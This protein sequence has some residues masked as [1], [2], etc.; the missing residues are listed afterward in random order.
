MAKLK[1]PSRKRVALK[2]PVKNADFIVRAQTVHDTMAANT[3]TLPS[4][5]PALTV[6]GA[7]IGTLIAKEAATK[8][9][10]PGAAADRDAARKVVTDDLNEERAYVETLVNAD[11]EHGVQIAAA[12]AMTLT[13]LPS[14]NKSDLAVKHGAVTGSVH[15]VAKAQKGAKA[16]EW[17]CSTDGGK[18]WT[19]LPTTTKASTTVQNLTAGVTMH[20]RHRPVTKTGVGDWSQP[21]S[22]L[23]V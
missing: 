16:N 1:K 6:L 10:T 19:D 12:A 23:V 11:P 21:V 14:R 15:V 7:D 3:S 18:T 5:K 9:R 17:Q 2:L 13:A 22:T 4:P 8:A 20:F